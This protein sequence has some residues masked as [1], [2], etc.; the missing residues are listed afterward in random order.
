MKIYIY[1]T[2]TPS[3]DKSGNLYIKYFHDAFRQQ[4]FQLSNNLWQLGILS[5]FANLKSDMFII[6]WV[7]LIP[8]KKCGKIQ[9]LFFIIGLLLLRFRRKKIVWIL[10]NKRAHNGKSRFVDWSMSLMAKYSNLVITHSLEGVDF[11]NSEYPKYKGKCFYIPHPVYS[12]EISCS[13]TF[14]WDYIIWGNISQR[15]NVAEFLEYA[16][17]I[18]YYKDKKV[19]ICGRCTDM[20]YAQRINNACSE[21]VTFENKFLTDSEL[22][23]RIMQ[24]R[25][26]LFTYSPD[27]VLSSGA[28]IYSLNFCKPIIGPNVGSFKDLNTIVRTYD[29]LS[30]IEKIEMFDNAKACELYI[31][32]NKWSCLPNKIVSFF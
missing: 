2:Y 7:D 14:K 3:R 20:S 9:F 8:N 32:E 27:S 18:K 17:N 28:L 26:V 11:F 4:G 29:D 16:K 13:E 21:N 22:S 25:C 10:H 1:P 30:Q 31:E 24:S 15:K 12:D 23:K 19:L 5:L 6:Q